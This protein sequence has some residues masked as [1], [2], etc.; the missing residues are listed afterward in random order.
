MYFRCGVGAGS[1]KNGYIIDISTPSTDL[2]GQTITVSQGTTVIGTTVFDNSGEASFVVENPGT[3]T[4]SVTYQGSTYSKNVT[5][6]AIEVELEAGFNYQTWLTAGDVTGTYADLAA[7]LADEEAVRKLMTIHAAVDYL[8]SFESTDASV[9][10][11][12]NDNYAAKWISLTDYAMDVLEAA[13]GTLMGTIG[14][15]GYGE[16]GLVGKVPTMTSNTAP[17]GEVV[18]DSYYNPG[19]T[20]NR[21]PYYAFDN[22]LSTTW[23][24][25]KTSASASGA[26]IGYKFGR[27]VIV[28]EIDITIGVAYTESTVKIQGLNSSSSWEDVETKTIPVA[29]SGTTIRL[30]LQNNTGYF[31]YRIYFPSAAGSESMYA[32]GFSEIQFYAW[33]P[34]GNV[35]VMTSNS[36]PYGEAFGSVASS[37]AFYNV[38][39]GVDGDASNGWYDETSANPF[40]GYGFTSPCMVKK[41]RVSV[42]FRTYSTANNLK[43]T[44]QGCNEK[45]GTYTDVGSY[46]FSGESTSTT[47]DKAVTF[48]VTNSAYYLYYRVR[49]NQKMM[50][51]NTNYVWFYEMQF[52][53]RTLKV[54]VPKMSGNTTPYGEAF[55]SSEYSS[56]LA[57]WKAF[58]QTNADSNDCWHSNG[59]ANPYLGYDFGSAFVPMMMV[60]V[61]RNHTIAYPP[62]TFSV[63]GSNEGKTSGYEDI[64]SGSA[65]TTGKAKTIVDM[66]SNTEA[67]RYCRIYTLTV[68]TSGTYVN[69]GQLQFYGKDY[70]EREWDTTHPRRYL[71]DHGVELEAL[72]GHASGTASVTEEAAQIKVYCGS[73]TSSKCEWNSDAKIDLTDYNL[74]RAVSG[75]VAI[76]SGG[77]G[78]FLAVASAKSGDFIVGQT[79]FAYAGITSENA[80]NNHSFDISSINGEYYI[81]VGRSNAVITE[82]IEELWL[83]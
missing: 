73:A 16:W 71:Y 44:L 17:S 62:A 43:L 46:T 12:L 19:G 7:V 60:M 1:G 25:A 4:V 74:I 28:K 22:N 83:E 81:G 54:S 82:T 80:Q 31:G 58:D 37:G 9:V 36:A 77:F 21:Y 29:T 66:S 18:Y 59:E 61:N 72:T 41:C 2:Y 52:Y 47:Y 32:G 45:N 34:V 23:H 48:D 30:S 69:I 33:E 57:A 55:A 26:Y 24:S 53:G 13:Y 68:H 50:N 65:G 35:P 14:K 64:A 27:E 67:Y 63:Q 79:G 49:M 5:I 20:S 76:Y 8:A 40:V 51:S 78:A 11:I 70:S 10:T 42:R 39:D 38:F 3:Y 56:T 6:S 15:Y 75:L